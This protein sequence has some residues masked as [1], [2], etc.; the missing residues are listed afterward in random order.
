MCL[1]E[2]SVGRG[3]LRGHFLGGWGV[4][5]GRGRDVGTCLLEVPVGGASRGHFLGGGGV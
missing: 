4:R 3:T 1:L 5:G 2:V